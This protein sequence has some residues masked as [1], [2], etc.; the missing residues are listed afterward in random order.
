MEKRLRSSL[1][2]SAVEFLSS[3]SKLGFTNASKLH[4]K[5]LI[6]GLKASSEVAGSLPSALRDSISQ[7]I[8]KFKN[9][10]DLNPD[11]S[12]ENP[13]NTPPA[14]RVRR[15]GRNLKNDADES[16]T[17]KESNGKIED[18][19]K[20]VVESLQLFAYILLQ[21]ISHP[22]G[23]FGASDLLP[24]ARE[25][26]DNL[27]LFESDSGLLSEIACVCEEWW[28]SDLIGKES[29]ITRSLPLLLSRALTS[30]KKVH[31]HRLYAMREAFNLFDFD[32]ESIVDLK[33]LMMRCVISPLFL[34][35]E[36]G[37][38]FIA[39][40]FGLSGQ[41]VKEALEMIRSQVPFGRKSA[42]EAFG[43]ITFRAWKAAEGEARVEIEDRFLQMMIDSAIHASSAAFS[44]SIRRILGGFISQRTTDGVEGVLFR[45][46]EPIIFRSLQV[47]NSNVR[48]NALHLLLD[49][50]PLEDPDATMEGK[51]SL[52]EKQ[53][54]LMDI[55]VMDECPDVRVVA[56]EGCC[57]ILH[58]FWEVIPSLTITKTLTKV[59]DQMVH[60]ACTDVRNSAVGGIIYLLG[61]P[62]SHEVLKVLLPRLGHLILDS[63]LSVRSAIVDLLLCL[64][65]IR[66]FYFHKV[67]CTDALLS[68]LA[69]DQSLVAQ[70]ITK[71]LLPS[72]FPPNVTPEE[73][74]KRCVTLIKR[75]PSAGSRFCEFVVSAGATLPSL[76]ELLKGLIRLVVSPKNLEKDQINGIVV[77]ISHLYNH[78]VK[79]ASFKNILKKELSGRTL[80]IMFAAAT[81]T[82]A[83]SSICSIISTIPPEAV[84]GLYEECLALITNCIGLSE[85]AHYINDSPGLEA[86]S[87]RQR[88]TKSSTR[89]TL[90]CK[91]PNLKKALN[92]DKFSF[93]EAYEIAEGIAW[94]VN[95]LLLDEGTRKA[96]LGSRILETALLGLKAISEFSIQ[97]PE[98]CG[99]MNVYP[100][101]AYTALILH[102]SAQNIGINANKHSLKMNGI[103]S[104]SNTER[105]QLD[106]TMDHLLDCTNKL[107]KEKRQ[108]MFF[109]GNVKI[110]TAVLKFIV[111]GTTMKLHHS[112]PEA[113]LKFTLEYVQFINFYLRKYSTDELQLTEEGLKETLLCLKSSFTYAAKLLNLVLKDFF[114]ASTPQPVAY[115]LANELLSLT[116]SIEK[117]VGHSLA[118]RLLSAARPWVPDLILAFG[119]FHLMN[120]T[121]ED[122]ASVF[123]SWLSILAKIELFELQESSSEEQTETFCKK[124]GF[125]SLVGAM[126]Q[127]LSANNDVLDAFGT[128]IL[129][130]LL[131]HLESRGFGV[132]LGLLHFVRV[133]LVKNDEQ[134][135]NDL[136]MMSVTIQQIY[137]QLEL[138]AENS[139][140]GES[141]FQELQ[142][143]KA[144]IEPVLYHSQDSQRS[145]FEE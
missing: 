53:F 34:K 96:L 81:T 9:L 100:L 14:K 40:M 78:L 127:R 15:S 76:M 138:L 101:T 46:A 108:V 111:D 3:A 77:G 70:K 97:Q 47:A 22:K 62:H 25:L 99:H 139:S 11:A 73:A 106:L 121:A 43:E 92:K 107:F 129:N 41:L 104:S 120:Q 84:D 52:L 49:L 29:L 58:M 98:R 126:V 20:S 5:T 132:L 51:D 39:F 37:R 33:H 50:F 30:T 10:N 123:P 103:E 59:F 122:S 23:I 80:K 113:C 64:S 144:L 74:C 114:D 16:S 112:L 131:V 56:V 119:S 85:I 17:K 60:D 66:N 45:L 6:H 141:E 130:I 1:H 61:K 19:R 21:S 145:P 93:T 136:K 115:H 79:E 8:E 105:T 4:L 134:K 36:D 95:D 35:M 12:G 67:V 88:K 32:D 28:K 102:L 133:K 65:D 54:F 87:T 137:C 48:Q 68:A 91:H 75:S 24:A 140:Y 38:K 128:T 109:L 125:K 57:R 44:A 82:H 13:P 117:H 118:T 143:A 42:L 55:L 27:V 135:W 124:L 94:Q 72:Y 83:K 89:T 116:V 63:A 31:V 2:T 71:L 26:H 69:S 90:K 7:A 86:S 18:R 142:S 110:L